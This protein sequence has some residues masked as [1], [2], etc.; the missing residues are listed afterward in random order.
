MKILLLTL[1]GLTIIHPSHTDLGYFANYDISPGVILILP[2]GEYDHTTVLLYGC[3][4]V[5]TPPSFK[6]FSGIDVSGRKYQAFL[7][8]KPLF[9]LI[10][11]YR[12]CHAYTHQSIGFSQGQTF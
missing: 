7:Y 11:T 10:L 3:A 1:L 4:G 12:F 2:W 6:S 5:I 9:I 8:R